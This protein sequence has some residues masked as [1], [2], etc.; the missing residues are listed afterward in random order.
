MAVT[1]TVAE[2]AGALR[3][4]DSAEETA[5]VTRLLAYASEAV[6]KHAPA[7]PDVAHNEVVV[8]LAG[9]LFDQPT[10]SRRD[11]YA[12]AFRN[13]GAGRMLLPYVVHRLGSTAEATT[14]APDGLRQSGIETVT[15]TATQHWVS[16]ALPYPRTAV[17]GVAVEA[18]DGASTGVEL[19]LTADLPGAAVAG[20]GDA[21]AEFG[22]KRYVLGADG[23]GGALFFASFELGRHIVRLFEAS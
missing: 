2:L 19:S 12:N 4:G 21:S 10:A 7:A 8:R 9:Y 1:L 3:L 15:V 23:A 16:T 18:P 22:S 6:V 20:G 14:A 17:F 13:S 5:E 11:A